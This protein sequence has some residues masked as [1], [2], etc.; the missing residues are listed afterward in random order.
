MKKAISI[1][2]IILLSASAAIAQ[3]AAVQ[4]A[5][6]AVFTLTTFKADNSIL[7]STHG[8][9]T[10]ANGEAV[11]SWTPFIGA[12]R[13]V[14]ID[15]D[16]QQHNVEAIYGAN[17]LY[18]V[19][20]FRVDGNTQMAPFTKSNAAEGTKLWL[21]GYSV[22]KP[23]CKAFTIKSTETFGEQGYG[24]YIF[25]EQAA[26]N[27]ADCP[28]VNSNGE[29]VGLLQHSKTNNDTHAV[30]V[31]FINSFQTRGLSINDAILRQTAIR[32]ALPDDINDA[33]LMLMMAGE[34]NDSALY[35]GYISDF[36]HMYPTAI[37]GY[38]AR[39]QMALAR[40]DYPMADATM[41]SAIDNVTA[42]DEAHS[43]YS[44]I[45]YQK[46]V[47]LQDSSYQAW[48]LQKALDEANAA[49]TI[50]PLAVYQHQIAQINYAMGNFSQAYQQFIDL[51]KSNI[52]NGELFYEA[53]Q[54]KTQL[55]GTTDEVIALLDSAVGVNPDNGISAPYYLARGQMLDK[56]GEYRKAVADYNK[57]DTLMM[58]RAS[59]EFYYVKFKCESRIRQYQQALNDIAHAIVLNR[60]EPTYYAEMASLQLRVNQLEEAIQTADLC[61]AIEPE[62]ADPYIVKGIAQGELNQKKEALETLLKAQ[63]LGDERAQGL[64][65]KYKK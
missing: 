22:K 5:G 25:N 51:T 40:A 9:F 6:K 43:A 63:E 11:S 8:V 48:S 62:Y 58:G 3:P 36:I 49:N 30:D 37:D 56:I 13:A 10:G 23:Q 41:Q 2:G 46:E 42:K 64:I 27:T 17:E 16:G 59:H 12:A 1:I 52:R 20:R 38:S 28:F 34:K 65:E 53:A 7:S 15:A 21:V 26:E 4:K 39:A 47:Y 60:L 14:V 54:C 32:T 44:S 18:D 35:A 24:Y 33:R 45:I 55:G 57:Y 19:C 61:I 29:I 50:N 31:R